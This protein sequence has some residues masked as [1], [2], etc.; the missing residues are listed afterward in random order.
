VKNHNGGSIEKK[1]PKEPQKS[2]TPDKAAKL[3]RSKL[4]KALQEIANMVKKGRCDRIE[5]FHPDA[6]KEESEL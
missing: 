1:F 6:G 5:V 4:Q 3:N 2:G